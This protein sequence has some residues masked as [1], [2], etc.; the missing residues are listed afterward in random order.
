MIDLGQILTGVVRRT[1]EGK[2]KWSPSADSD[3]FVTSVDAISIVITETGPSRGRYRLE[4]LDESGET[5]DSLD[6]QV[7]TGVQDQ[8]LARLYVLARR[9]ALDVD[10][11]LEKLAKALEL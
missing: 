5:V 4:I 2:L 11:T 7:T 10:A 3:Q 8:E 6:D 1:A 9:S